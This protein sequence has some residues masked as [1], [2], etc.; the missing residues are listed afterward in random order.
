V[1]MDESHDFEAFDLP[2]DLEFHLGTG[3][4]DHIGAVRMISRKR[5]IS[6]DPYCTFRIHLLRR[7]ISDFFAGVALKKN[8]SGM[9][10]R[11]SRCI[12]ILFHHI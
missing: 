7:D 8:H 1:C 3:T 2:D 9:S 6:Y 5:G 11:C 10:L 4:G 12:L